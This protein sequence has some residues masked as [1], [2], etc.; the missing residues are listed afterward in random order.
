MEFKHRRCFQTSVNSNIVKK[1]G[2]IS[3]SERSAN[4]FTFIF[5]DSLNVNV[6]PLKLGGLSDFSVFNILSALV[7]IIL[8]LL[9][10][11]L[12]G[13]KA[14]VSQLKELCHEIQAN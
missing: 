8:F 12:F 3:F 7:I 6:T 11:K 4:R 1:E 10:S 14:S 13:G 2:E 9:F 5:L